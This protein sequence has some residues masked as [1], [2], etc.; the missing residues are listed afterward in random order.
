MVRLLFSV[1]VAFALASVP[2]AQEESYRLKEISVNRDE[3]RLAAGVVGQLGRKAYAAEIDDRTLYFLDLDRDKQLSAAADGLA[4]EGQPFVVALPEKLL[5]SR[6]QY[7]FRFKGVRELV[8]TR[9]ELGHD[10]EIFPMAIAITEVRI[11]AGLTPFVVDQVASGHARQHLDYLK[12]NS[13]VSGRLT[14]EAHGEDPRR[15]GYSQGGAYAGRYGILAAGRSLSEDVMSWFT[16]AYHGAKLLDARVRRIGLARRHH[17]SLICPVPGAEE[18]AVENFQVHPPDGARAVPA[19]FSSGGEVPSPIP[20]SSLGAG[21]GFP[22]FVLLPT[23]CQMAR[24][25]TF[26]LRASSGTSIRGHLSSPAQPANPLFPRNVG[27][28]FFIPST[29]LEDGETYTA[30]FQMDG[31]TEPLVWSFQTWDWEL[32]A[33]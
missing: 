33:R 8:L 19:N 23:R 32:K 29:R 18:R 14:M 15:P 2:G 21:K 7:S 24:V 17:L 3:F 20:G 13:I 30:T 26:E 1:S 27:C 16:S 9:E 6:G 10:E 4:I 11:R 5:L 25:T 31:M 12:R 22:L 28:A